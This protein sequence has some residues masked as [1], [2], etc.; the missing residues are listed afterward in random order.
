MTLRSKTIRAVSLIRLQRFD[1]STAEGRSLER[2]RRVGLTALAAVGAKGLNV[3]TLLVTVPL[4]LHYLG[5]DR[6]G[7]WMTIS[8]L[9]AM[10]AFADLG[11]NAALKTL[12]AQAD[13]RGDREEARRLISSAYL[14][15][16]AVACVL[17]LGLWLAYPLVNWAT[18]YNLTDTQ[19]IAEAGPA[20]V[21]VAACFLLNIPLGLINQIQAGFQEGFA[22]AA[23]QGLGS[24][25]AL[26]GVVTAVW[27][28]AGLAWLAVAVS[29]SPV[30]ACVLNSCYFFGLRQ[31]GLRPTLRRASWARIRAVVGTGILF[32]ILS[33]TVSLTY[34]ADNLV[35]A[36]TVGAEGVTEYSV[37][38]RLFSLI[39]LVC[40]FV[41]N[42]FWAA[43]AEALARGE[44][45]WVRKTLAR[46]LIAT[47]GLSGILATALV[48]GQKGIVRLWVGPAVELPLALA[49]GMGLWT[50]LNAAA[51]AIAMFLNGARIILYQ[52]VSS[53]CIG[54]AALGAK[55]VLTRAWGTPGLPWANIAAYVV[56]GFIPLAVY[57]P[58]LFRRL[59]R[60][61]SPVL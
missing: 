27:T 20:T 60:D 13:G 32:L 42:P 39:P 57:L 49:L 5:T 59:E 56:F 29:G 26:A 11:M 7:L 2:Y 15:L 51:G 40:G 45:A 52:V 50:V 3:V 6:F 55:I 43:Y 44:V 22:S 34:Y 18:V 36:H 54:A 25:L 23:W 1:T 24:L 9:V 33:V 38:A 37:A 58:L 53:V 41:L 28:D 35:A 30:L 8:S 17:L 12:L 19:A 21:V 48:V 61:A 4:T 10:F 16:S 14:A 47:V 31:A 46:S